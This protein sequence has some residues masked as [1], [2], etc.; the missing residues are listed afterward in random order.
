M[1][2]RAL[3]T[4]FWPGISDDDRCDKC[5]SRLPETQTSPA[6]RTL[7]SHNVRSL[8]WFKL[9]VDIFEHH[10]PH[11]LLVPDYFSK[12]PVVTKLMNLAR[13][14]VSLLKAIF[15]EYGMPARLFMDQGT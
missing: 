5:V 14:G 3:E 11:Y 10:S 1:T 9:A 12:F 7:R 13:Q 15:A 6:K 2:L 8:P 4:A